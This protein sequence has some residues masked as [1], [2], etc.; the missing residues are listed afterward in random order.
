[1]GVSVRNV[2]GY[3]LGRDACLF[4]NGIYHLQLS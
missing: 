4:V 3:G 2:C 1:M